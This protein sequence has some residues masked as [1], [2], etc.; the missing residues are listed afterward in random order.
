MR[1]IVILF[2]LSP[3]IEEPTKIRIAQTI[4]FL[5]ENKSLGEIHKQVFVNKNKTLLSKYRQL[6]FDLKPSNRE[7][8]K[9]LTIKSTLE[10]IIENFKKNNQ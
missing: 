8:N 3:E 2:R 4:D 7:D 10:N 6:I 1:G 5:Y 9:I